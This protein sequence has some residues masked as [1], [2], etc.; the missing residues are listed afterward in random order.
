[1]AVAR[2]AAGWTVL[3]SVVS[4]AAEIAFAT[5]ASGT[6][7]TVT[8]YGIYTAATAGTLIGYGA[9]TSPVSL[10]VG[11]TPKFAINGITITEN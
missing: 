2:S 10:I 9:L 4:N 5:V 1:M 7:C 3:N 11:S 6:G 8:Y